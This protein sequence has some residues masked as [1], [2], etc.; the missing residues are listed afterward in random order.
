MSS[1]QFLNSFQL[2]KKHHHLH[3]WN[4]NNFDFFSTCG[5]FQWFF[6]A[7]LERSESSGP[8]KVNISMISS[9]SEQTIKRFFFAIRNRARRRCA[10]NAKSERRNIASRSN[11]AALVCSV[12]NVSKNKIQIFNNRFSS[13]HCSWRVFDCAIRWSQPA[14][15]CNTSWMNASH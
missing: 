4:V 1:I 5:F 15:L 8:T 13:L 9:Q 14:Q 10:S 7:S 11:L 3:L 6:S 2:N 12:L